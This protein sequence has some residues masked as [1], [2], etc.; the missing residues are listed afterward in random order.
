[1]ILVQDILQHLKSLEVSKNIARLSFY[2]YLNL[3]HKKEEEFNFTI[4]QKFFLKNLHFSFWK[5]NIIL[6]QDT[7][8]LDLKRFSFSSLIKKMTEKELVYVK[9]SDNFL[10]YCKEIKNAFNRNTQDNKNASVLLNNRDK[11]IYEF[12]K[13]IKHNRCLKV[14]THPCNKKEVNIYTNLFFLKPP[15]L[16]N[17][18]AISSLQ[19]DYTANLETNHLQYIQISS[20]EAIIFFKDN[21][22][23]FTGLVVSGHTYK[24]TNSFTKLP[25]CKIELLGKHLDNIEKFFDLKKIQGIHCSVKKLNTNINFN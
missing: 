22:Q 13:L 1:M 19:Y 8:C 20:L 7:L 15:Y 10:E 24:I 6:L 12:Q 23:L 21:L 11:K 25:L 2:N 17:L 14:F 5:E 3:F 4:V 16:Q 18:P 9:N